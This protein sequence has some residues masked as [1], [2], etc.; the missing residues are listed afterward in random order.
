[1]STGSQTSAS[2]RVPAT[3][4]WLPIPALT[5]AAVWLGRSLPAW[6]YMWS[7][8]FGLYFGLKW[9]T[10]SLARPEVKHSATRALFYL[11]LWPGMDAR[12]FLDEGVKPQPPKLQQWL[13]AVFETSFGAVLLWVVAR[14]AFAASPLLSG[15]VGL[16]GLIFLLHFGSFQLVALAWQ[17]LG[18][19][20]EPI[21][22][23][24]GLSTS[25]SEFWGKRWN[26]GFRQLSYDFVFQPLHRR[27]GV[28]E[29]TLVVFVLS[30]LIHEL[31]ISLPAHGGY[32]L[33]TAYF[34]LQGAGVLLERSKIGR[35]AGLQ[36][37]W[38]GRCFMAAMTAGPAFWLFHPPFVLRVIVPFL[39]A[40]KA[41]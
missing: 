1:M 12:T 8:S 11:A 38:N 19:D 40:V 37:G 21:M 20:A 39:K 26:L 2:A 25:L 28:A 4:A 41:L 6:A 15:W 23:A 18:I 10:F 36:R 27:V 17:S 3:S 34:S 31:A 13:I 9:L 33:P 30:G 7:I 22:R 29:A 35:V 16:L 32:G 5:V 24:P 14:S